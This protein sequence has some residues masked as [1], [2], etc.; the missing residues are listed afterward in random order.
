M[1]RREQSRD[2]YLHAL[3]RQAFNFYVLK[4]RLTCQG[5]AR[6]DENG[7]G[8][9]GEGDLLKWVKEGERRGIRER[10]REGVGEIVWETVG[11]AMMGTVW[12]ERGVSR[13]GNAKSK[14][15]GMPQGE[16]A[17]QMEGRWK[18]G[19]RKEGR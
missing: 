15:E 12:P 18:E 14:E 16:G 7:I 19:R 9:R 17:L 5:E 6:G 10:T 11:K 3:H 13:D 4:F 2:K 8:R 1:F